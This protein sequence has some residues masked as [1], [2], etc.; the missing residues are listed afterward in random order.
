MNGFKDRHYIDRLF[1]E[2]KEHDAAY[3]AWLDDAARTDEE[4][5]APAHEG[6][7]ARQLF[8]VGCGVGNA[9]L[10]LQRDFP[11]LRCVGVDISSRAVRM[12]AE[13]EDFDAARTAVWPCDLAKEPLPAG[14]NERP[15]DF[16]TLI[17][18]LSAIAPAEMPAVL[19]KAHDSLRPG[20]LFLVRDYGAWDMAMLRFKAKNYIDEFEYARHN[21]TLTYFFTLDKMRALMEEAGFEV[22]ECVYHRKIIRN[23]KR[24]LTMKRVWIHVKARRPP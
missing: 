24:D 5:A 4:R 6:P 15:S 7:F 10:P 2:L 22:L 8:E 17:F 19:R 14:V 11:W 3:R 1:G 12:A 9:F 21:G 16:A 20:G 18:V 23:V 13:R